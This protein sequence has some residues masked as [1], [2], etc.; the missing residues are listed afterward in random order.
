MRAFVS[1]LALTSVVLLSGNASA[2]AVITPPEPTEQTVI[3]A[4]ST[5]QSVGCDASV[6]TVATGFSVQT[7]IFLTGC[8]LGPPPVPTPIDATFGPLAAGTYAYDVYVSY[9]GDVPELLSSQTI[10]VAAV[11]DAVPTADEWGLLF[12]ASMLAIV[13]F[14]VSRTD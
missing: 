14:L 10:V 11:L 6:E 3:T 7:T 1:I 12:L 9:E 5:V 4:R 2:Q 13:G 8:L